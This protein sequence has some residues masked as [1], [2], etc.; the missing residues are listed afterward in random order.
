MPKNPQTPQ[1]PRELSRKHISRAERDARNTRLLLLGVGGAVLLS[2]VLIGFAALRET[3]FA[4]NE[5][6]AIVGDQ[7][8][9]TREFQRRVRLARLNLIS[10]INQYAQTPGLESFVTQLQQQLSDE[11]GIG[12]QVIT[13]LINEALFRQAAPDL[14]V[15]VTDEEVQIEIEQG[16]RY[17]RNPPTPEPTLTPPPTATAAI[18]V[19]PEP[20]LTPVPTAT[21]VTQE[22]FQ[23]L[24]QQQVSGLAG[25]GFSEADY[26]E[27]I[28][29]QLIAERVQ[30]I[31]ESGV[32]TT[33]E[34]TQF[35]FIRAD[36]QSTIDAV[37][38]NIS[39]NG[40]DSVY[41]Q[42]LSQTF[43]ITGLLAS[44]VDFL[45]QAELTDSTNES[46]A[47]AVF[48]T[49]ISGTFGVLTTTTGSGE[50]GSAFYWIG[51]V[52]DRGVRELSSSALEQ[53]RSQAVQ[54]WLNERN[55]EPNVRALTWEDRVPTDP[56]YTP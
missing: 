49:P 25:L 52:L 36:S 37:Q 28:R 27:Y 39:D 24:Y 34:Q 21:P 29:A 22:A 9:L 53:R 5:P 47:A 16:L 35:Q 54:D 8:I 11:I 3:V 13:Q 7:Q 1:L 31:I 15:S 46:F 2:A 50:A 6:V 12:S 56:V 19:T 44:E 26:R 23:A 4:P 30:A 40:F 45:P 38:A 14:G 10:Q 17:F 20:T 32:V 51:R 33:T 18:T 42:V 41:G 55:K 43:P 48:S